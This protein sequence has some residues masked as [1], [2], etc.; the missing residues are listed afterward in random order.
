MAYHPWIPILKMFIS[1]ME[2]FLIHTKFAFLCELLLDVLIHS[3]LTTSDNI[4]HLD[5]STNFT[6]LID[7]N[8]TAFNVI[9][10]YT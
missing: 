1:L 7:V 10:Y 2:L 5:Y 6:N 8:L 3:T 9:P 4:K